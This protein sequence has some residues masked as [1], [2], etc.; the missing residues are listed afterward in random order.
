MTEASYTKGLYRS[1]K[2][3]IS[4]KMIKEHQQIVCVCESLSQPIDIRNQQQFSKMQIKPT[5]HFSTFQ[6]VEN[7]QCK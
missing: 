4:R 3:T 2:K 1:V 5:Y 7:S 6:I